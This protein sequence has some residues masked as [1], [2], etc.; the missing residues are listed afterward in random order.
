MF[1]LKAILNLQA[2]IC[3]VDADMKTGKDKHSCGGGR[4]PS[5]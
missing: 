2:G 1:V 3:V 4:D 5:V